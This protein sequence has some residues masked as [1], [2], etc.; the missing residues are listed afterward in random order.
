MKVCVFQHQHARS[1]KLADVFEIGAKRMGWEVERTIEAHIV[2]RADLL[3][4][5]GWVNAAMFDAY[6]RAGHNYIYADLGY[7]AR[8]RD[9]NDYGGFHK[10]VVNG[11]HA[12]EYFQRRPRPGDRLQ[13]APPLQPWRRAGTNIIVAGLS[14]KGAVGHGMRPLAWEH[15]IIAQLRQLTKRPIVYRPKPSWKDARPIHGTIF[16]PGD[17]TIESELADAHALVT[18]SSNAAIDALAYGVPV[19]AVEGLA[20]V[21]STPIN[22]IDDP[23]RPEGRKQFFCDVSYC[24]WTRDEVKTGAVFSLFRDEGLLA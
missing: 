4:A 8:K 14:A 10:L 18:L 17:R 7:W 19:H 11:R 3:L 23:V 9:R 6:R 12:T 21:M 20:S 2:P 24:H 22:L 5:Y 13:M 1:R 16:S 15:E